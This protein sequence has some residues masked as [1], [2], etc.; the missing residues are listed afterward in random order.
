MSEPMEALIV[1]FVAW[2]A[3]RARPYDEV[4]DAWRTSC[5]RLTVWEEAVDRHLVARR[6]GE[7]GRPSVA[8]TERGLTWL[9][10]RLAGQATD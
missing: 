5:P 7:N 4:M 3:P 1:D 2:L 6:R 8:V 9:A 10:G